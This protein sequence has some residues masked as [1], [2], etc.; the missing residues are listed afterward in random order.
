MSR[1]SPPRNR[2]GAICGAVLAA[3]ALLASPAFAEDAAPAPPGIDME[4]VSQTVE[5]AA[6]L[7]RIHALIVAHDGQTVA[8]RVFRGPNL[9]TP[10]NIKSASKT[11]VSALV[12]IAMARGVLADAGAPI[13]PLL[14][15]RAPAGL[16]PR[17]SEITLDHLLSMRAGLERT[18]GGNYG[19]WV[20][21]R[22]WVQY[23]LS[24]PFDD[25]PGGDMLYSTGNTHL[26][27]AILTDASGKSTLELAREL[28]GAPLGFSV[29]AWTRDPQGIYFGGNE[30][31]LSPRALLR[32]GEMY[33]N[34][35]VHRGERILPA[36]WVR[37]SW[38]PKVYDRG[39]QYYGYTWFITQASGHPVYYAWGFGGQMLYIAPTL[40]LT[41]VVTSDFNTR[42]TDD[43]YRCE[44]HALVSDGL[45]PAIT[46]ADPKSARA[47][48]NSANGLVLHAP[49]KKYTDEAE[50]IL[51][52][53]Q[54]LTL[55]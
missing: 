26:L 10:V 12:G 1:N 11:V 36:S 35:G 9:D 55:A 54:A 44:L 14:R 25:V 47:P 42:S 22:N 21:S 13:L 6:R 45:V 53:G 18:S 20:V 48:L 37:D 52:H 24:R 19:P 49:P 43:G 7:P 51:R 8:E 23:A 27:S 50:A 38:T 41:V 28:L 39:G 16:D 40:A 33:R 46:R 32:F 17:V 31:A 15:S 29:P 30:M 5:R 34:G 2:R 3:C 4:L